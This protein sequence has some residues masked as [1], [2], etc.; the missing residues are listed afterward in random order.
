MTLYSKNQVFTSHLIKL[1]NVPTDTIITPNVPIFDPHKDNVSNVLELFTVL[2]FV[3]V[4]VKSECQSMNG[5]ALTKIYNYFQPNT[6]L[7]TILYDAVRNFLTST[8]I[9][10]DTQDSIMVIHICFEVDWLNYSK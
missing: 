9:E 5:R 4:T 8:E 6:R 10:E 7:K 2:I 1:H 3:L